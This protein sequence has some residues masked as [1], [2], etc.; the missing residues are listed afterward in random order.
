MNLMLTLATLVIHGIEGLLVPIAGGRDT[1]NLM[2]NA[3]MIEIAD[4][5]HTCQIN[6]QSKLQ[7]IA[8]Y[9]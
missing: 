8:A 1:S 4:V 2:H 9:C 6:L 7:K 5:G 3:M